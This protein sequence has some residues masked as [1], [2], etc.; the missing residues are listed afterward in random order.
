MA[1]VPLTINKV[2]PT[3][4][5]INAKSAGITP[6]QFFRLC[7]DN[8]DL[9]LELTARKEIVIMPPAGGETDS[10]NVSIIVQLSQWAKRDG[11]GIV[12]GPTGGFTLPNGAV[13]AADAAWIPREK[14]NRM[15]KDQRE[16][17]AP[18]CPDFVVELRSPSDR[19]TDLKEKMQ[20]YIE[21]G[22]RLGWLI[23]RKKRE[24]FV[25]RP[26]NPVECLKNPASI[27]AN[28]VL[29]GFTL[30]LTEIWNES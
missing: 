19:M 4:V 23:N 18:I 3:K 17:F 25:Y 9:Q 24:V 28:P 16:K 21:N 11:T 7:S 12:F 2:S 22:V 20:E 29:P 15:S 5:V 27:S 8:R 13:R 30:D 10:R 26:G 6:E 14:W 1:R